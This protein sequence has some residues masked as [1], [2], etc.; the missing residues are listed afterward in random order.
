MNPEEK[1]PRLKMVPLGQVLSIIA[2]GLILFDL[3]FGSAINN[4][5][6]LCLW[7][8]WTDKVDNVYVAQL[9]SAALMPIASLIIGIAAL[10]RGRQGCGRVGMWVSWLVVGLATLICIF[11]LWLAIGENL[12]I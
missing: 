7:S 6:R 2:A 12:N 1:K 9:V 10:R 5:L 11:I 3:L 4:F 8:G